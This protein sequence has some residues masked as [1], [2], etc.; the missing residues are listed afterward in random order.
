MIQE[1]MA[2]RGN[3]EGSAS[4]SDDRTGENLELSP[5]KDL[6]SRCTSMTFVANSASHS[7][8]LSRNERNISDNRSVENALKATAA[9]LETDNNDEEEDCDE[10][11]L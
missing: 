9:L 5:D 8:D 11:F 3:T 10:K 4:V 7:D 6:Q 1:A 2:T